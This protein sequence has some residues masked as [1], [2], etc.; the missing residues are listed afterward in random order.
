M[1]IVAFLSGLL[2]ILLCGSCRTNMSMIAHW[3]FDEGT[4]RIAHDECG[5][6]GTVHGATWVDGLLGKALSFDGLGD[7]VLVPDSDALD[8]TSTQEI[9]IS[10][11][12]KIST[13]QARTSSIMFAIVGKT[14]TDGRDNGNYVFGIGNSNWGVY[15]GKLVFQMVYDG[16]RWQ[17]AYSSSLVPQNRWVHVAV[18]HNVGQ[19]TKF[20]MDGELDAVDRGTITTDFANS[21]KALTIGHSNSHWDYFYGFIDDVRMYSRALGS[22]EISGLMG[23]IP[24]L[25]DIEPDSLHLKNTGAPVT[26]LIERGRDVV[27]ATLLSAR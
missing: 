17:E 25:V 5:H 3:C 1:K 21:D 13:Y 10:A 6:D 12:V 16:L 15:E 2:L 8:P 14:F 18:T 9:T 23:R 26:C 27:W 24:A 20:Y 19:S 7:H 22:Q 4:G 11:W